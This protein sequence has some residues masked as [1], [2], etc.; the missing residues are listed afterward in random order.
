VITNVSPLAASTRRLVG[1]TDESGHVRIL[2]VV[3]DANGRSLDR[4][5]LPRVV[6]LSDHLRRMVTTGH[7]AHA[8]RNTRPEACDVPIEATHRLWCLTPEHH[9]QS[10]VAEHEVVAPIDQRGLDV[11][12]EFLTK[13]ARRLEPPE[14][15]TPNDHMH[16]D[17][18]GPN[19]VN[20]RCLLA[21][22]R[23]V[24]ST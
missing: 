16:V 7:D 13:G 20:S 21:R 17:A 9:I 3:L 23:R 24:R 11:A 19:A 18:S 10:G 8:P 14:A 5:E 1:I 4:A 15:R 2:P 22:T 12:S 6:E